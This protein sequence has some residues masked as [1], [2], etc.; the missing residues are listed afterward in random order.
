MEA[1]SG[2]SAK[3]VDQSFY[4]G[5]WVSSLTHSAILGL[6]DNELV[7]LGER[8]NLVREIKEQS[9]KPIIVDADTGGQIELFPYWVKRYDRAGVYALVIEDKV[10]PK[11]NSLL[12]KAD[13]QLE[14][15]DKFCEKIRAGKLVAKNIKIIARLESLIAKRSMN[16]ALIRGDAYV[17]A[18]ADMILIHSKQKVESTEVMEFAVKFRKY[19]PDIP[20]VAIP[21]TYILPNSHPFNILIYANMMLRASLRAMKETIKEID[22]SK[23]ASVEEIFELCGH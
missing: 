6:P 18:G 3:L 17:K 12:E 8:L 7:G 11:Q 10:F 20:L 22:N 23:L 13:H 19:H 9:D 15:I 14:R 21:T 2:L 5:I 16:E 1:H 4:N